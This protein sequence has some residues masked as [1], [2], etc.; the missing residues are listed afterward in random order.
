MFPFDAGQQL[1]L[2]PKTYGMTI[3]MFQDTLCGKLVSCNVRVTP[4]AK[5]HFHAS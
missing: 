3:T 1:L 5:S 2:M 4:R